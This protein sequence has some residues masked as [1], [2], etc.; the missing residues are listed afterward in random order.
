M[1]SACCSMS[2]TARILGADGRGRPSRRARRIISSAS[3]SSDIMPRPSRSTLTMP[4]AAQ[5]SLSH[6]ITERPGMV[7]GSSGTTPSSRPGDHHAARVLAEMAR[8]ILDRRPQRARSAGCA[9][10]AGSQPASPRCAVSV[11][12]GSLYSQLLTSWD[13]RSMRSA[14]SAER[15]ADLARR[16]AAAIGDDVG[17]HRRA[18][19]AVALV[20]VLDDLL[21]PLAA[22]Q[23]EVDVRPLAARLGEEAL[24]EQLHP[25]RIDGGDPERVAHRAVGRR[26]PPLH[27]DVVRRGR[28]GRC[29]RR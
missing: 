19:P 18:E 29:P 5:S 3:W 17:G 15:L 11:S 26:A 7:A 23:V 22:R 24:E 21:A 12:P 6:W 16:A 13:S 27:E 10:R 28:T 1:V 2:Y 20:D 4:S 8:Q 25:H 9:G 14:G